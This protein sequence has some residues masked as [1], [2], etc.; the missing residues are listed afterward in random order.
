MLVGH[1]SSISQK[2][3]VAR[4]F[5]TVIKKLKMEENILIFL[6]KPVSCK[7]RE[8]DSSHANLYVSRPDTIFSSEIWNS[9][10]G[11]DT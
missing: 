4:P 3:E 11:G 8:G 6:S 10:T 2:Q 1:Y 9:R 7:A 5:M